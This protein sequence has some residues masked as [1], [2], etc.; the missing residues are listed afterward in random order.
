HLRFIRRFLRDVCP[1]GDSD[2]GNIRHKAV[3]RYIERHARDGSVGSGR[4]RL[5]SALYPVARLRRSPRAPWSAP[6]SVATP[7]TATTSSDTV[8]PPNF[9]DP[10]RPCQR[11]V[12]C[13]DMRARTLRVSM[14]KWISPDS[15]H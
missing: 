13:L 6:A 4:R 10:V 15:A 9:S 12:I 14:R 11:S 1:A 8:L 3:I 2:L 5:T 7:T